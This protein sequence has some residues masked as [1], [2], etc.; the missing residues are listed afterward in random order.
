MFQGLEPGYILWDH[1][2]AY[3]AHNL[4][5]SFSLNFKGQLRASGPEGKKWTLREG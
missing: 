4:L 1:Y 2:A 3:Y 5:S